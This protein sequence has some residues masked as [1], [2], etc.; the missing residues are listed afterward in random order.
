MPLRKVTIEAPSRLAFTLVD[1]EGSGGRINGGAGVALWQPRFECQVEPASAFSV[2]TMSGE[3]FP[4]SEEVAEYCQQLMGQLRCAPVRVR[5]IRH[6][7]PHSGFGSKTATLL[8]VGRAV[9]TLYENEVSTATLAGIGRRAGTSGVGVNTFD[10]GGFVVDGGHSVNIRE[11]DTVDLFVPSRFSR[12]NTVPPLLFRSPFPWPIFVVVPA[13][14]MIEGQIELAHF[15]KVCPVP[16]GSAHEVAHI[17]CFRMPAAIIEVDYSAF[18]RAINDLQ[19]T[20]WKASQI[21]N[22]TEEVRYVLSNACQHGFD[23]IGLSS[24]GPAVYGLARRSEPAEQWLTGLV[25]DGIV[26]TFWRAAVPDHGAMVR[27]TSASINGR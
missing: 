15:R 2:D 12:M 9:A 22:Q 1:L 21:A 4:Y 11:S 27:C 17:V 18:C 25:E 13:G 26:R 23:G 20:C 16:R 19:R 5:V 3:P 7:P 6:I 24:N 8:S 10:R 14:R